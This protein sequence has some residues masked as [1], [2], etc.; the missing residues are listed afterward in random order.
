MASTAAT[1]A[2]RLAKIMR[3]NIAIDPRDHADATRLMMVDTLKLDSLD[4]VE[5][6]M[7]LE[8]EFGIQIPDDT[9]EPFVADH[10]GVEGKT[11][12]DWVA[13]VD[14]MIAS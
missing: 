9:A 3:E 13:W 11:F 12:G 14:G 8:D 5:I 4:M 10:G 1:T 2:D 7:A 6:T